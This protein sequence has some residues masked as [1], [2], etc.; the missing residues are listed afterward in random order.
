MHMYMYDGTSPK[1][2]VVYIVT[3]KGYDYVTNAVTVS[4]T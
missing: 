1:Q 4:H 2:K 3:T